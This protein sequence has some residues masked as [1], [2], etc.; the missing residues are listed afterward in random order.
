MGVILFR[1]PPAPVPSSLAARIAEALVG[2]LARLVSFLWFMG[3][4]LEVRVWEPLL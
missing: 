3:S 2:Y 4:C 1:G